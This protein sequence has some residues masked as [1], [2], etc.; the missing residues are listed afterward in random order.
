MESE[1]QQGGCEVDFGIPRGLGQGCAEGHELLGYQPLCGLQ[2]GRHCSAP[3]YFTHPYCLH[4]VYH[5][6]RRLRDLDL[7]RAPRGLQH[8]YGAREFLG[9]LRVLRHGVGI[10]E[11]EG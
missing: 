4:R 8:C 9:C 3:L 7:R 6:A 11:L 1:A 2:T 5:Q 10:Q